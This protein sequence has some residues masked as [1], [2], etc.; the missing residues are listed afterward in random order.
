VLAV[1]ATFAALGWWWT[2]DGA[3]G[4]APPRSTVLVGHLANGTADPDFDGTLREAVTVYLE[5]STYLELVSDERIRAT[6][7][8]MGRDEDTRMTHEIAAELCQRLGLQ[9]MIEGSVSAV[10]RSTVI[11]LVASD[12]T[13]GETIAREQTEV[14]RKEEVLWALG[15]IT[16]SVRAAL[17]ESSVSLE[18]HNVPIEDAT[19]PS[20]DALKAYTEAASRRAAGLELEA[21]PFL[22][23]AI[24]IDPEF[25]LAYTTLSSLYGAR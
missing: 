20:L 5:Q 7:R 6:L 2:R 24:G 22:E 16:S 19:T 8:M 15:E 18:S 23:R 17:G 1:V 25:A 13:T 4:P 10:G 3:G 12:C 14:E 9:A 11:A 21:I